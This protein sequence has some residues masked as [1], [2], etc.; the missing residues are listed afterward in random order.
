ME[1]NYHYKIIPLLEKIEESG[2]LA[3]ISETEEFCFIGLIDALG[4]GSAAFEAASSARE[5]L[6]NNFTPDPS[7]LIKGMHNA[8][9]GSRGAVAAVAVIEKKN[10]KIIYSGI[11]NITTRIFGRNNRKF[12]PKDGIIG[13]NIP[14]PVERSSFLEPGDV[15]V[16]YSDGVH[17]SFDLLECPGLLN[18]NT[19]RIVNTLLEKFSKNSDDASL[20]A[21]KV[22]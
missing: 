8:L 15:L 13:Y 20:L 2:D 21:L 11:G 16:M 19:E 7:M 17:E 1:L 5:Y 12:I 18:N 14:R 10:K 6:I 3:V 4:H 9:K 22:L